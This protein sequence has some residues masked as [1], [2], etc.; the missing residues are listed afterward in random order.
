MSLPSKVVKVVTS[1]QQRQLKRQHNNSRHMNYIKKLSTSK[2]VRVPNTGI[3]SEN[4]VS[5]TI[6]A[7]KISL[8]SFNKKDTSVLVVWLLFLL[9]TIHYNQALKKNVG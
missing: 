2:P 3:L 9:D 4:H 5:L 6:T 7:N 1:C 8:F